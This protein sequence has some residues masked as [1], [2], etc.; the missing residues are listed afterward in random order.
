MWDTLHQHVRLGVSHIST[1]CRIQLG[2]YS[3]KCDKGGIAFNST[4]IIP[5]L[6]PIWTCW[7]STPHP[8]SHTWTDLSP[9]SNGSRQMR[10][11]FLTKEF[12]AN[13]NCEI[14]RR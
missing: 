2:F 14:R 9:T 1:G 3:F 7:E 12:T 8:C 11:K 10:M 4:G 6:A 5:K 13:P